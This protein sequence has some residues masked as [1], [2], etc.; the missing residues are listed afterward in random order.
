MAWESIRVGGLCIPI[1]DEWSWWWA[2]WKF[3]SSIP[4]TRSDLNST[5]NIPEWTNTIL[6]SVALNAYWASSIPSWARDFASELILNKYKT[7]WYI[8]GSAFNTYL[9]V[10]K[11]TADFDNSAL[12]LQ[13][14]SYQTSSD[15]GLSV[16]YFYK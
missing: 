7:V 1:M 12:Q 9:T 5:I 16:V 15:T 11:A 14:D 4:L 8:W 13:L 3:I 2:F 6:L 10:F